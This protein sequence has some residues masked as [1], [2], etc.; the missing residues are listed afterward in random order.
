LRQLQ[1][2]ASRFSLELRDEVWWSM[3]H[4]HIDWRGNGNRSPRLRMAYVSALLTMLSRA[5]RQLDAA[6]RAFQIFVSLDVDNAAMDALFV[7]APSPGSANFPYIANATVW[8]APDI[9]SALQQQTGLELRAGHTRWWDGED[10][11][12]VVLIYAPRFGVPIETRSG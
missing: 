8:G 12:H 9:E 4:E 10:E 1:A 5:A 7:H 2:T 6:G 11:R 3:G